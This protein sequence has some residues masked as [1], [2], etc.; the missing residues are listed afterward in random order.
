MRYKNCWGLHR[1]QGVVVVC[2]DFG[3]LSSDELRRVSFGAMSDTTP[4]TPATSPIANI[5]VKFF[6][7]GKEVGLPI[8]LLPKDFSTG[9]KGFFGTNK[10]AIGD[11]AEKGYMVQVQMVKIGSKVAK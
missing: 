3:S 2:E 4:A 10:F 9:S 7:D 6:V 5:I 1:R 8:Q 11:D